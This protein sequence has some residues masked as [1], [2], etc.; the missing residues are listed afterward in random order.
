MRQLWHRRQEE[1]EARGLSFNLILISYWS[2]T[3]LLTK[4]FLSLMNIELTM[5]IFSRRSLKPP[6]RVDETS[7]LCTSSL[8]SI[9]KSS[10][11]HLLNLSWGSKF[12]SCCTV[13]AGGGG[14]VGILWW[15]TLLLFSVLLVFVWVL[16]WGVTRT[17]E[18]MFVTTWAGESALEGICAGLSVLEGIWGD[19]VRLEDSDTLARGDVVELVRVLGPRWLRN[20]LSRDLLN[21]ALCSIDETDLLWSK[22][23][24]STVTWNTAGKVMIFDGE[25]YIWGLFM[26]ACPIIS[27]AIYACI[28]WCGSCLL[29]LINAQMPGHDHGYQSSHFTIFYEIWVTVQFHH[30]SQSAVSHF[31]LMS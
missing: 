23:C 18:S 17:V 28:V 4:R 9:T 27:H 31:F 11:F 15:L 1:N 21:P 25:N 2:L 3:N 10:W 22:P 14:G 7:C 26:T 20:T 29:Q 5:T 19:C 24:T 8:I 16:F 13:K 30:A 6:A 12:G